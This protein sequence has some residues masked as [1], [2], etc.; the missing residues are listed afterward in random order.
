MLLGT[1]QPAILKYLLCFFWQKLLEAIFFIASFHP[2]PLGALGSGSLL[3]RAGSRDH[4][5]GQK[6]SSLEG[7]RVKGA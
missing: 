6:G 2:L 7:R 3:H 4:S 5:A 1:E